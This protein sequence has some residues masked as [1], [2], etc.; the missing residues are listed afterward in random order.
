MLIESEVVKEVIED[1]HSALIKRLIVLL[2]VEQEG[3]NQVVVRLLFHG[4]TFELRVLVF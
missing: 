1:L 2:G 3:H 4:G